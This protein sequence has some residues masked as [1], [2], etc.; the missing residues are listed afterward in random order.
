M[1]N[2][3]YSVFY[4]ALHWHQ[5][6]NV[7]DFRSHVCYLLVVVQLPS[8]GDHLVKPFWMLEAV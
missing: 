3:M 6:W 1:V 2:L 8:S 7:P 4:C 5:D